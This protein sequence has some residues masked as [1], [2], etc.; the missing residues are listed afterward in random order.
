MD[1][2][3]GLSV[4]VPVSLVLVYFDDTFN[5]DN[6]IDHGGMDDVTQQHQWE[7]KL[8]VTRSHAAPLKLM[9]SRKIK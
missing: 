1:G 2:I 4:R 6:F 3:L 7:K 9:L 5:F 8:V